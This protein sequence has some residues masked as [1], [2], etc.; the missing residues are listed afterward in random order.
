MH[1]LLEKGDGDSRLLV[2][3]TS[4]E[5][6]ALLVDKEDVDEIFEEADK[7]DDDVDI[8]NAIEVDTQGW[9]N[10][11]MLSHFDDWTFGASKQL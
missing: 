4:S 3:T 5:G 2:P 10:V 6:I 1:T 9:V 11:R 8:D 7:F